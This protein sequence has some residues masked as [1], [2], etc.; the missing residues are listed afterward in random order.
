MEP[1]RVDKRRAR[2][3]E[4]QGKG[5]QEAAAVIDRRVGENLGSR[6]W[7]VRGLWDNRSEPAERDRAD[8]RLIVERCGRLVTGVVHSGRHREAVV[9]HHGLV[10]QGVGA[11]DDWRNASRGVAVR[12]AAI[13]SSGVGTASA[14]HEGIVGPA[15]CGAT[16]ASVLAVDAP[17]SAPGACRPRLIAARLCGST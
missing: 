1:R 3:C 12:R 8:R 5:A 10:S 6:W 9:S 16:V 2:R 7:A 17:R 4:L 15:S 11:A 13:G 14:C